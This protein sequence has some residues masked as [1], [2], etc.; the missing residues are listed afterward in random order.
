MNPHR[1]LDG[2]PATM[3]IRRRPAAAG[4]GQLGERL[5]LSPCPAG[6]YGVRVRAYGRGDVLE[7]A[8]GRW[9]MTEAPDFVELEEWVRFAT[10]G[11]Q[12][13]PGGPCA[14]CGLASHQTGGWFPTRSVVVKWGDEPRDTYY[15]RAGD[16]D[17]WD[18]G[19]A[20]EECPRFVSATFLAVLRTTYRLLLAN[21]GRADAVT[22]MKCEGRLACPILRVLITQDYFAQIVE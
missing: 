6:C 15:Y 2:L 8:Q 10:A 4:R 7:Q 21:V 14:L 22:I 5:D 9:G 17:V 3:A 16:E 20:D 13:G 19:Y 11:P 18:V 12:N 1:D